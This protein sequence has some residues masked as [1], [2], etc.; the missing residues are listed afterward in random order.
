MSFFFKE[1]PIFLVPIEHVHRQFEVFNSLLILRCQDLPVQLFLVLGIVR[2]LALLPDLLR[3]GRCRDV[4]EDEQ[5]VLL[6]RLFLFLVHFNPLKHRLAWEQL[7]LTRKVLQNSLDFELHFFFF[8]GLV[9]PL[10]KRRLLIR[11]PYMFSF[12]VIEV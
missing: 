5:R 6:P 8:D 10:E 9:P 2:L 12:E 3:I 1:V 7:R 11:L 4:R